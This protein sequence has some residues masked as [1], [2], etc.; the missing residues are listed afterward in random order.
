VDDGDV[1]YL[2]R[3]VERPDDHLIFG[4]APAQAYV[5]G[6][7]DA[8]PQDIALRPWKRGWPHYIRVHDAEF[9]AGTLRNGVRLS[10]LMDELG[11]DSF[12]ITRQNAI[13]GSGNINPRMSLRQ[14]PAVRL[15][16]EGLAWMHEH[17]EE[18]LRR[19]GRLP[20]ES[21]IRLDWPT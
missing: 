14:Q 7:D 11:P 9:L 4:R 3:M 12:A 5:D 18:A 19:H 21:L 17:F 15:S 13:R 2:A 8:S 10:A 6:R 20:A 16:S 1:M